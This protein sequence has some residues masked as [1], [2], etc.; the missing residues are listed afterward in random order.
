MDS[1][2]QSLGKNWVRAA[3]GVI[4]IASHIPLLDLAGFVLLVG[5]MVS[6]I[7]HRFWEKRGDERKS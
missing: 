6:A 7:M 3:L 4:L 2:K 1:L 5:S